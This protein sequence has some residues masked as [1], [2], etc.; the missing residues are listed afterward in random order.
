MFGFASA[1]EKDGYLE[2]ALHDGFQPDSSYVSLAIPSF[3]HTSFC[4]KVSSGQ[5]W[6]RL[7]EISNL[8]HNVKLCREEVLVRRWWRAERSVG[9]QT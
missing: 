9:G 4:G 7:S 1:E 2:Q 5:V 3:H 8:V 6:P